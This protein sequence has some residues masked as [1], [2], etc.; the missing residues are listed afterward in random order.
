M[1]LLWI[2]GDLVDKAAARVSPFDHGFL[3]GDGVWEPLRVFRGQLFRAADH[4]AQLFA[5]AGALGI[6]IPL[7]RDELLAAVEATV[8]ANNRTEGYVRVIVTRGPGTIGPDPRK[9]DPQVFITAEE[10]LP[11]PAELYAHGLHAVTAPFPLAASNPAEFARALGQPGVV[12]A[13]AHALANGCL[14]AILLNAGGYAGRTTEG[15]L[16]A[17]QGGKVLRFPARPADV[18]AEVVE[19]LARP[20]GIPTEPASSLGTELTSFDELFTAGTSCGVIGVVRVDGTDVGTGSEGPVTRTLRERY[21]LL[22]R[23]E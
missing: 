17:V 18:T 14:E 22:T 16:F 4:L 5:A 10:Y 12:L 20:A 19:E 9:L 2:N 6:D 21:R 15:D 11:F 1:S 8:R 3:Y 13:K 23:G 7:S